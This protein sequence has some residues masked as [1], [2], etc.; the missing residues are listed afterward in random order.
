MAVD[1][2]ASHPFV[3]ARDAR[4][5]L[6]V[7]Y[8]LAEGTGPAVSASEARRRRGALVIVEDEGR[9]M[10]SASQFERPLGRARWAAST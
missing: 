1:A 7:G 10:R 8:W 6:E 5:L 9:P 3:A 2:A 4:S